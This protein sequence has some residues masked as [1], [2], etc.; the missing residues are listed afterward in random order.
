MGHYSRWDV[1][2]LAV[3]EKA[4]EPEFAMKGNAGIKTE[5]PQSE[6]RRIS[7]QYGISIEN[8]ESLLGDLNIINKN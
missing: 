2:Q 3:N 5:L 8:L 1:A 4:L 7:E 6:L